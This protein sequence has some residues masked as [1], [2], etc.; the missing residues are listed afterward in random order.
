MSGPCCVYVLLEVEC[1]SD[2]TLQLFLGSTD[3]F[4]LWWNGVRLFAQTSN[5]FW[6]PNND[7]VSAR[8]RRGTNQL[9]LKLLRTGSDNRFSVVYREPPT[10]AGYDSCPFVVDLGWR[11]PSGAPAPASGGSR[12]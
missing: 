9:V 2:R 5:R 6:F 3:P 4:A 11:I 12:G 1:P 7:V 8:A 10:L